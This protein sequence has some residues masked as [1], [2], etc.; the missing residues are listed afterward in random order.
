MKLFFTHK[1]L[2]MQNNR[3][4][5]ESYQKLIRRDGRNRKTVGITGFFCFFELF[6]LDVSQVVSTI[7]GSGFIRLVT[8]YRW[9]ISIILFFRGF[10]GHKL[11]MLLSGFEARQSSSEY[12]CQLCGILRYS[13]LQLLRNCCHC[14]KILLRHNGEHLSNCFLMAG[15][16]W[17]CVDDT[18]NTLPFVNSRLNSLDYLFPALFNS[19]PEKLFQP[20]SVLDSLYNIRTIPKND[21]G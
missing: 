19:L 11:V 1:P 16:S 8:V 15:E 18:S 14:R 6:P 9:I 4:V 13:I 21:P 2:A 20:D 3:I 17:E 5:A 10:V 7:Y 12:I